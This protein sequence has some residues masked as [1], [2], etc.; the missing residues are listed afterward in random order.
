MLHKVK[1]IVLNQVKY[2]DSSRIINCYTDKFGRQSYLVRGL[3]KKRAKNK[4]NYF[5]PF[6]MLEMEAYV[7]P[8]RELQSLKE[9]RIF[10]P[11]NSIP[12]NEVKRSLAFFLTEFLYKALKEEESNPVMFG[13]LENAIRY[14][15]EAGA[16]K[17]DF[18]L[19]FLMQLS[20]HLGI[21]P[22]NNYSENSSVFDLL[23]GGFTSKIPLHS[24]FTEDPLSQKFHEILGTGFA[25]M[26][27]LKL[28]KHLRGKL[29][30]VIIEYYQLHL[31]GFGSI[32]SLDVLKELF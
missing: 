10:F 19:V 18:H 1:G 32:F 7:K 26:E 8:K 25:E 15:D 21:F 31:P 28:N 3:G 20:K 12:Y 6:F 22:E 23:E 29:L 9:Y 14:L 24:H 30:S 13:F 27:K 5:Q 16:E 4:S 17:S 2:S 11:L